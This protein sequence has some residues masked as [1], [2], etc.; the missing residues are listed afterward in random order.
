MARDVPTDL[1]AGPLNVLL[2]SAVAVANQAAARNLIYQNC[3]VEIHRQASTSAGATAGPIPTMDPNIAG[4]AAG[5]FRL[6]FSSNKAANADTAIYIVRVS[7][8]HSIVD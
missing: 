5:N 7:I 8:R 6:D 4:G 3:D 1:A 2:N